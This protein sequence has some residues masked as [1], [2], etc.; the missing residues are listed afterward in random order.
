MGKQAKFHLKFGQV[1]SGQ[2]FWTEDGTEHL[3]LRLSE[4][5]HNAPNELNAVVI[6]DQESDMSGELKRFQ[7]TTLVLVD[8]STKLDEQW[9]QSQPLSL[10][11]VHASGNYSG[12]SYLIA[13]DGS[14]HAAVIANREVPS[15]FDWRPQDI[16][17]VEG[18]ITGVKPSVIHSYEHR[19]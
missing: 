6:V 16:R 2:R 5:E 15:D 18:T 3:R 9:D 4:T 10:F 17:Q 7:P 14:D 13:A 11:E 1:S 12:G 19:E 8:D